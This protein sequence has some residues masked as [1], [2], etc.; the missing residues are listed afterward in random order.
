[1]GAADAQGE[2]PG[3]RPR[4]F[5][6]GRRK[7]LA[8]LEP[9]AGTTEAVTALLGMRESAPGFS[10]PAASGRRG[11]GAPHSLPAGTNDVYNRRFLY[12]QVAC[13]SLADKKHGKRIFA[14]PSSPL[15]LTPIAT[16]T[17]RPPSK[18]RSSAWGPFGETLV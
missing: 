1:M 5:T 2:W 16:A 15:L 12:K 13:A 11:G 8:P 9:K 4:A 10:A 3:S 17:T 7:Y 6:K 14:L 18:P